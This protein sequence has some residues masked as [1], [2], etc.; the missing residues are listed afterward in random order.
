MGY[1]LIIA[2][3]NAIR[4]MNTWRIYDAEAIR[5]SIIPLFRGI[6]PPS[7]TT[8][9]AKMEC[10]VKP[11]WDNGKATELEFLIASPP[12]SAGRFPQ[13]GGACQPWPKATC[14]VV[15]KRQATLCPRSGD[16]GQSPLLFIR[17]Y[18]S[19]LMFGMLHSMRDG[20]AGEGTPFPA[21]GLFTFL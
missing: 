16:W 20:G 10:I 13:G 17:F 9:I 12:P 3:W 8:I 21:I 6:T 11:P 19:S 2:G 1:P 5:H 7:A 4:A 14:V 15:D 18:D